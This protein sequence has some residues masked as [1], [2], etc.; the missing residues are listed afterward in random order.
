MIL[1]TGGTGH[2]GKLVV[3]H[4]QEKLAGREKI[5]VSTRKPEE[6]QYLT[7]KGIEVRQADY[8]DKNSMIT[9]L[10]G[11]S[12]ML[13][14]SGHAPNEERIRQHKNVISAALIA[15]VR[16]TH[17][18]SFANAEKLSY[19]EFARVHEETENFIKKSGLTYTIYRNALY[20]DLFLEGL[21]QAFTSGKFFAAA[22]EGKVNSIP[23]E[24]I[25]LVIAT[26]LAEN[27]HENR[28]Y[29]LTGPQTFTYAQAIE[30]L[31]EAFDKPLRYVDMGLEEVRAFYSGSDPYSY[32]INGMVSNYQ[33][34]QAGEY[35]YVSD[36]FEKITG[37]KPISVKAFFAKKASESRPSDEQI[38]HL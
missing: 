35:D 6:A 12:K 25:A 24:E 32:E 21:D 4:L 30:W 34:I 36:D 33:A 27:G 7:D 9:A 26:S 23:R 28:T 15:G 13:L 17:Y 8:E 37:R 18:T 22:G 5:A 2:L 16:H 11:V 19:F 10:R 3:Q 31:S 1:I 29:H 20:A 38:S 14:I